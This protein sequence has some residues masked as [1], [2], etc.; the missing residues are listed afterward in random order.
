MVDVTSAPV[1]RDVRVQQPQFSAA[2]NAVGIDNAG[3]PVTQRLHLGSGQHEPGFK[4]FEQLVLVPG[5]PVPRDALPIVV[6]L[7]VRHG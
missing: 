7:R 4:D 1:R 2:Y 6:C 5:S 3:T